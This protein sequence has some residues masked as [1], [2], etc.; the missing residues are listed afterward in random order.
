MMTEDRLNSWEA[1]ELHGS[2]GSHVISKVH[3]NK[4][5]S[6]RL[7]CVE[8]EETATLWSKYNLSNAMCDIFYYTTVRQTQPSFTL[9]LMQTFPTENRSRRPCVTNRWRNKEGRNFQSWQAILYFF[10]FAW[11][12]HHFT[13]SPDVCSLGGDEPNLFLTRHRAALITLTESTVVMEWMS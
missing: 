7:H 8:L 5:R 11:S 2:A 13:F 4:M 10:F 3:A 1:S 6:H 12:N 9:H